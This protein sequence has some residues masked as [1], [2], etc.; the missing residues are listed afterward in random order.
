MPQVLGIINITWRG[1]R[2]DVEKG[3]K[4]KLG[5]LKNNVVVYGRKAGRAQEFVNSEI[6][7]TTHL[8][9]GKSYRSLYDTEEGELVV[10]CDTGQIYTFPDAF[11]M[12]GPPEMTGGEGGK[13]ELKWGAGEYEEIVS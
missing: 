10:E 11:L 3:A 5:G 1:R 13:I 8:E 9:R 4:L 12:D 6:T 7:A 2:I